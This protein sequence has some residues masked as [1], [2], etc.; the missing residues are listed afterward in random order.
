MGQADESY[1][2]A[3]DDTQ[4]DGDMSDCVK[5]LQLAVLMADSRLEAALMGDKI[6]RGC[7]EVAKSYLEPFARVKHHCLI[8]VDLHGTNTLS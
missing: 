2:V 6:C 3:D 7:V 1:H 5:C 4:H 8:E